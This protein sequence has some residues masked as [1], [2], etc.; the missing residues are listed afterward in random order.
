MAGICVGR[1]LDF[2]LGKQSEM[3]ELHER[4]VNVEHG[5]HGQRYLAN[6][7]WSMGHESDVHTK[8]DCFNTR[9]T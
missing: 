9:R 3:I 5:A 8:H 1:L 4:P 7:T 2:G 6:G